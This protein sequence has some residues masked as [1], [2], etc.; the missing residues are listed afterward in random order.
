MKFATAALAIL[1]IGSASAFTV[2][3]FGI[4]RS[5]TQLSASKVAR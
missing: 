3:N 1:S 2:N 4:S 5:G